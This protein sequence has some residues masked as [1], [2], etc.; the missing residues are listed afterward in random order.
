[1][2]L[3][4][5]YNA[6]NLRESQSLGFSLYEGAV[7]YHNTGMAHRGKKLSSILFQKWPIE[8][9]VMYP[10]LD[11]SKDLERECVTRG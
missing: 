5:P 9:W 8:D 6:R 3:E 11:A 2:M 4:M 7:T 1:M 10:L